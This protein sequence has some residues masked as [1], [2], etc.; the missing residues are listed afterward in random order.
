MIRV[1]PVV[2]WAFLYIPSHNHLSQRRGN[3]CV[4]LQLEELAD[5]VL[6]G[7][8]QGL[9]LTEDLLEYLQKKRRSL[10]GQRANAPLRQRFRGSDLVKLGPVGHVQVGGGHVAHVQQGG[11]LG[12][13]AVGA[14]DV[15]LVQ[16]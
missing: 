5:E 7:E 9:Q 12:T 8:T 11:R 16:A 3:H 4:L 14:L 1:N 15:Q 10:R 13:A 2:T 6:F